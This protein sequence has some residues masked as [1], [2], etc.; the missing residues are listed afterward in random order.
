MNTKTL[1]ADDKDSDARLVAWRL[2]VGFPADGGEG[3][4]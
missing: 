1:L 4:E 2:C 3:D